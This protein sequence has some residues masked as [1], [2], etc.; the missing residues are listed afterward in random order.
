MKML[1]CTFAFKLSVQRDIQ[2]CKFNQSEHL[3]YTHM[4]RLLS[5]T[6]CHHDWRGPK[7][8]SCPFRAKIVIIVIACHRIYIWALFDELLIIELTE[9]Q[10]NRNKEFNHLSFIWNEKLWG[11]CQVTLQ[12]T[13]TTGSKHKND[14][15]NTFVILTAAVE[16][17]ERRKSFH[18]L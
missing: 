12:C 2:M 16:L 14:L 7:K 18:L 3:I 6:H 1:H 17:D 8:Y 5:P 4:M 9:V 13:H 10:L 11:S 15:L